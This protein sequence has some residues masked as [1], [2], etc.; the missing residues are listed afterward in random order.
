VDQQVFCPLLVLLFLCH[1]LF[2]TATGK[3]EKDRRQ[4]MIIYFF[5]AVESKTLG[6]VLHR[7]GPPLLRDE[8]ERT[9]SLKRKWFTGQIW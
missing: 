5:H 6:G 9:E 4:E 7:T 1:L 8:G 3:D 2:T